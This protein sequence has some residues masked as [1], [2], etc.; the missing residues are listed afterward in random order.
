M[1]DLL[2]HCRYYKGETEAPPEINEEGKAVF[3][4]YEQLWVER[5][6]F[7]D[8]NNYNTQEYINFGLQD[9]NKDDGTPLTLKAI[10]FNRHCHWSGGYGIENDIKTFK[11]W[12]KSYYLNHPKDS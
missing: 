4:Y 2:K 3:W 9:F 10:L 7:R 1:N 11:E 12:Y 8:E 5:E 6:E